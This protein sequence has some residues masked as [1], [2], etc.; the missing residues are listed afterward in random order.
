[1]NI[2]HEI[3]PDLYFYIVC[4]LNDRTNLHLYLVELDFFNIPFLDNLNKYTKIIIMLSCL[5]IHTAC[6]C[7]LGLPNKVPQSAWLEQQKFIVLEATRPRLRCHQGWFLPN[8]VGKDLLQVF[9]LGCRWPSS[10]SISSHHFPSVLVCVCIQISRFYK[11]I[12][13][14]GLGPP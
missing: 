2:F 11:D 14:I 6:M 9:L 3:D 5:H 7:L 13:H 1:M 4:Y 10:L 8:A 12:R